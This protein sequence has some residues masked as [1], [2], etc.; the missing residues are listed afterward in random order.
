MLARAR[1]RGSDL[2]TALAAFASAGE[3]G[4]GI[5]HFVVHRKTP[6]WLVGWLVDGHWPSDEE[7]VFA[8]GRRGLKER[9]G[10]LEQ[11]G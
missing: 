2:A 10:F 4:A 3:A 5:V 8:H 7:I 1:L 9:A 6:S 11:T